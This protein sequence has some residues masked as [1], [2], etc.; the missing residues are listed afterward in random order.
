MGLVPNC[1]MAVTRE[2]IK[3]LREHSLLVEGHHLFNSLPRE[4]T[5]LSSS[6]TSLKANLNHWLATMPDQPAGVGVGVVPG[7]LDSQLCASNSVRDWGRM[8]WPNPNPHW[9]SV[10][11]LP[12][13][14]PPWS[15]QW[16]WPWLHLCWRHPGP[17]L[18]LSRG[19]PP[20]SFYLLTIAWDKVPG[21]VY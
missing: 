13:G 20:T 21:M 16:L 18:K 3:S 2:A 5:N 8:G 7:V 14:P 12:P 9:W 11:E 4:L 17:Q 15:R 6:L 1:G 10:W 19:C